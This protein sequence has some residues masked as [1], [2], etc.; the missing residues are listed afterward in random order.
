MKKCAFCKFSNNMAINGIDMWCRHP[1][2]SEPILAVN[3][4]LS[5]RGPSGTCGPAGTNWQ[6]RPYQEPAEIPWYKRFAL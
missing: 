6:E 5:E 3:T 4:C 1:D 2:N